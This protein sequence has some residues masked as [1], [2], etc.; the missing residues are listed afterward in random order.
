MK[1]ENIN[2]CQLVDEEFENDAQGHHKVRKADNPRKAL[3]CDNIIV[4][5]KR[6]HGIIHSEGAETPE[7]LKVLAKIKGWKTES[8]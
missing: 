2:K 4:V 3:D 5:K 7:E 1:S 6:H 8:I